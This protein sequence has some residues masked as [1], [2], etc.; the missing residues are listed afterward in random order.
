MLDYRPDR[1]DV[2]V[3]DDGIPGP[4][5]VEP[6]GGHGLIG[7]QERVAVVGGEVVAGPGPD[8]GFEIR[9]TLP[10]ALEVS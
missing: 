4:L 1:L 7:I 10:Y 2:T 3:T 8:G 9:A 6:G 5:D